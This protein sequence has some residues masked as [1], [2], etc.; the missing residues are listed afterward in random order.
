MLSTSSTMRALMPLIS[1]GGALS[2]ISP[3]YLSLLFSMHQYGAPSASAT[4]FALSAP[5][6][7]GATTATPPLTSLLAISSSGFTWITLPGKYDR[8][9]SLCASATS[10]ALAPRD[11]RAFRTALTLTA[12]PGKNSLSC[13]A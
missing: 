10:S 5:P 6:A 2:S 9:L 11:A 4:L 8:A 12:S 3:V 13:L 7:S 1:A